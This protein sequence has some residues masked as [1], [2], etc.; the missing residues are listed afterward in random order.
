MPDERETIRS[1]VERATAAVAND[2][3]RRALLEAADGDGHLGDGVTA[4]EL[5][6]APEAA[7]LTAERLIDIEAIRPIPPIFLP[8]SNLRIAGVERTQAIQTFTINGQG[9]GLAANGVPLISQKT[10]ILRVYVNRT[11]YAWLPMPTSV[12]GRISY[13]GHPDLAPINGPIPAGASSAINRG[14]ANH[15][16]LFRVPASHCQGSVTFTV[17]VFDPNHPNDPAWSSRSTS[18]TAVFEPVPR[19]RVHGVLIRYTGPGGPIA[20]PSGI[21][22]VNTLAWIVKTYP[23]SGINYIECVEREFSGDLRVGGGGGCGTGWNQLFNM[24]WNMRAASGTDDVFVG[25]LPSGVPTSGVIGCGGGGVAISYQGQGSVLAQEVGHAFGRDHAPCGNPGGPDPNY[26][27]YDSYPS[28][29]IGEFGFDTETCQVHNPASTFDFMSYCGPTWVSPYTYVGLKN[30]ITAQMAAMH[31]MSAGPRRVEQEN[32]F[33]NFEMRRD[34]SVELLPSFV[35]RGTAPGHETG[36]PTGISC[37][38]VDQ[39]NAVLETHDC[40]LS[41]PHQ[42]VDAAILVMREMVPFDPQVRAIVFR[43]DGQVCHTIQV[44]DAPPEITLEE[45][46]RVERRQDLVRLEWK[47]RQADAKP[48]T[49]MVRY[50]N[51]G[52]ATWRCVASNLTETKCVIDLGLLPGGEQAVLQVLASSGIR[53]AEATTHPLSVP[54]KPRNAYILSPEPGMRIMEGEPLVLQGGGFSPDFETSEFDEVLWAC[55]GEKVGVGYEVV[56]NRLEPGRHRVTL[57]VPDGIGAEAVASVTV[58]VEVRSP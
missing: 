39:R 26:P 48:M 47:A 56:A 21:D 3:T 30:A 51:D 25:L 5:R 2:L 53:T 38:L 8:A 24:I 42:S 16:L 28:A 46:K 29:S 9:S 10:L 23:I 34:G 50:S 17:R 49:Y 18:F 58:T 54:R 4:T 33:L 31:P 41:D 15:T 52:G 40:H 27:T 13:P 7:V 6:E 14:N 22:L 45:P 35:V 20:A 37:D 57:S 43:R 19:V 11:S 36:T 1:L 12:T 44:E 32:L 55:D